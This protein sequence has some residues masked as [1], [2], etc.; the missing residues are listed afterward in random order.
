MLDIMVD[1][2]LLSD[3]VLVVMWH[4]CNLIANCSAIPM[5]TVLVVAY[6]CGACID[7]T[8]MLLAAAEIVDWPHRDLLSCCLGG[9]VGDANLCGC[10]CI[11]LGTVT[12]LQY[13]LL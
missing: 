9:K 2:T 5:L 4:W 10:V 12:L 7:K 6:T 3:S 8:S 13:R 1:L 11:F